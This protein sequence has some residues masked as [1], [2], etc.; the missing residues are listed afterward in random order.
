[1]IKPFALA[2]AVSFS[3]NA[4]TPESSWDAV[5]QEAEGQ[6]VYFNAWGG[7]PQINQYLRWAD[8]T[9][10]RDY[11]VSLKHVKVS[12]IAETVNRL[13][14]E[15]TAGK[16]SGGSVDMVWINGENFKSLKQNNLLWG[17]FTT[18]LPNW[19]YIDTSLPIDVDF[20]EPT[21]G[22][23]APWGVGQLVFIYDTE[24]MTSPPTSFHSLL[25][26]AKNHPGRIAYP[27]PPEFH[28]S[29]FLKAALIELSNNNPKLYNPVDHD[30][31]EVISA[32]L[33]QYLDELHQVAWQR[34]ERFPASSAETKQL[35]DDGQIDLAV[36]FNPNDANAS[37]ADGSLTPSAQTY[38]FDAGALS[39][40]H[41]IGIPWNA[42][43]S[44]GALVAINFLLSPEAQIR[45][46][47]S[48][49]WGDPAVID[50][51][52]LSG[53]TQGF[54]LYPSLK[55]PHPSWQVALE[56]SWQLRYGVQ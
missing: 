18:M 17:P 49:I 32:P 42:E 50:S 21:L 4:I 41:F 8:Q 16:H 23:E 45:K 19:S 35:L 46:S 13:L 34:G 37:I 56:H 55:E 11:K 26:Y 9:L 52:K 38:A 3:A 7:S 2:L 53:E 54:S 6:T 40:I 48:E 44:A 5:L 24:Q 10:Q 12:D 25:E 36:T 29:S 33:W 43:H 31:F 51:S 39:N 1:M 20:T 22:L 47:D 30:E 14:A 28:G 15:K 27:Q